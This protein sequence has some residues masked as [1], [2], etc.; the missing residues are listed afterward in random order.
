MLTWRRT[1][2]VVVIALFATG[3][4]GAA[5]VFLDTDVERYGATITVA[6]SEGT[7]ELPDDERRVVAAPDDERERTEPPAPATPGGGGGGGTLGGTDDTDGAG[8]GS[9][10]G[11][12]SDGEGG[13][14][15]GGTPV[16]GC[17]PVDGDGVTLAPG[18]AGTTVR[19][20]PSGDLVVD[21]D[22][23]GAGLGANVNAVYYVGAPDDQPA[24]EHAFSI[25]NNFEDPADVAV[26]YTASS[27]AVRDGSHNVVIDV[28]APD[29]TA[30]TWTS[31]EVGPGV[32]T[33]VGAGEALCATVTVDTRS[34][35]SGHDLGGTI[36]VTASES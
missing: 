25:T 7:V 4:L 15:G 17:D 22:V 31:E 28:F 27:A 32:V 36:D 34:L 20:D 6:E 12:T 10:D 2:T 5:V 8:N 29:G 21:F 13:G 24:G 1:A 26:N 30:L 23:A 19:T 14:D 35:A 11:N 16:T 3:V 18:D 33:G 9:D